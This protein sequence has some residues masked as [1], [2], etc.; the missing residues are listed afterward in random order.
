[1]LLAQND[2]DMFV[3]RAAIEALAHL[4]SPNIGEFLQSL[5]GQ[6]NPWLRGSIQNSLRQ[7]QRDG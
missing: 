3:R 6:E 1:M 7:L 5:I 2:P 4:S